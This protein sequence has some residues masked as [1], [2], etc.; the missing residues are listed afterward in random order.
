MT[1]GEAVTI[2][3]GVKSLTPSKPAS[4]CTCGVTATMPLLMKSSTWPSGLPRATSRAAITPEAPLLFST[5][6]GWPSAFD[7][8]SWMA[9]AMASVVPPAG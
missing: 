2:A 1:N 7:S 8:G 4:F 5:I 9:R 3:T 6:T